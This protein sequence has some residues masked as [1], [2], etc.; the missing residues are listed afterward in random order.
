VVTA[1]E[2]Y[3]RESIVSPSA[4]IVE[5]YQPIM[6]TYQGQV[7]EEA[8]F[9]LIAYIQT[10]KGPQATPAQGLSGGGLQ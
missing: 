2:A 8:L 10:L 7:S 5:G 6:P 9:Q 1:D 4:K 3:L